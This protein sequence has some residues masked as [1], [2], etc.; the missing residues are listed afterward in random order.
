M[1]ILSCSLQQQ[2]AEHA[3]GVVRQWLGAL[4]DRWWGHR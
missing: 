4:H 2:G 1:V 3:A